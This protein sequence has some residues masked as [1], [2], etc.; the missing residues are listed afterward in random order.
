MDFYLNVRAAARMPLQVFLPVSFALATSLQF[1]QAMCIFGEFKAA[2][3]RPG[4]SPKS[5]ARV[6]R[7]LVP[8]QFG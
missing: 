7:N 3:K 6:A 2:G 1:F 4:P 8:T 5:E